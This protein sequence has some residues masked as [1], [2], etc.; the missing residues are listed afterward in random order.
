MRCF[1]DGMQQSPLR[2]A[3]Y[4]VVMTVVLP[5]LTRVARPRLIEL[6][7]IPYCYLS[8]TSLASRYPFAREPS[9]IPARV[10]STISA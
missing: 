5:D 7:L 9:A 1:S 2:M 3:V 10:S 6:M 8:F 4:I